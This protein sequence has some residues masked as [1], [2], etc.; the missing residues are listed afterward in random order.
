MQSALAQR[1]EAVR[2]RIAAS[3]HRSGRRP[4]DIILVAVTKT[5]SMEQ[6]R[7]L[8]EL[9]HVDFG[10]SRVQHLVQR[11]AQVDE[12]LGRKRELPKA[13]SGGGVADARPNPRWHMIGHLQRNKVRRVLPIARLIHSVDSLRLAEEIQVAA[14]KREEPVEVLV[15]VNTSGEMSKYG[16]AP[17]AAIHL[18]EQIESMIALK[19]RG[20]MC[21]APLSESPEVARQA[22]ERCRE[23]FEDIA[24]SGVAGDRFN[25]LSMGMSNDFE[26][27]IECGA[28]IVRV[29][30]A[31]FGDAA[32]EDDEPI[33]PEEE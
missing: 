7:E 3:A 14:A 32:S 20:L 8:I 28:N 19:A 26:V 21:M 11:S 22:F 15:Q 27:A 13:P 29:G 17:P 30:S 5:A 18:V 1:F 33:E 9:G 12:F 2:E 23:L 31:I 6:V 25:I 4:E 10:E 16:V 24:K